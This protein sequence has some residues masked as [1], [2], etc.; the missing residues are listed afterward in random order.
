VSVA[1]KPV[2]AHKPVLDGLVQ[3]SL[4]HLPTIQPV[5]ELGPKLFFELSVSSVCFEL[6]YS[7]IKTWSIYTIE[8]RY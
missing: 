8:L 6:L 1:R 7:L 4:A 3:L 2:L 5:L